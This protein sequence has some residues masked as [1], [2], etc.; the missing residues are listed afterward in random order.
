[1]DGYQIKVE[2]IMLSPYW[3]TGY[4]VNSSVYV[5]CHRPPP[6]IYLQPVWPPVP[7]LLV[8]V[9]ATTAAAR[10][11]TVNPLTSPARSQADSMRRKGRENGHH[12]VSIFFTQTRIFRQFFVCDTVCSIG[13]KSVW[14]RN[15]YR[16]YWT[17]IRFY[18]CWN[19]IDRQNSFKISVLF[20]IFVT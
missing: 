18:S 16:A 11:W 14:Y 20:N 4:T 12:K 10:R 15:A 9:L 6:A 17:D 3:G 8:A 7:L 2:F 13:P 5:S 1:V 19:N